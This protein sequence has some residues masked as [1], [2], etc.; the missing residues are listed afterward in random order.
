[1]TGDGDGEV[2]GDGF[3]ERQIIE[4]LDDEADIFSVSEEEACLALVL[5]IY[6]AGVVV[7]M[8]A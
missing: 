3:D 2:G 8:P 1:M 5:S 4:L 7:V 6:T